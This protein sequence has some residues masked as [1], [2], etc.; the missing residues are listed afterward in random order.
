M[1]DIETVVPARYGEL[2]R[3]VWNRDPLRPISGAEALGLY[4]ANWRHVEVASLSDQERALIAA[5]AERFGGG[6]LLTTK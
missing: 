4:E 2:A 1:E 3:L 5:L 6:Y